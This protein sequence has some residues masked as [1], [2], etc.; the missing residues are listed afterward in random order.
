MKIVIFGCD[1]HAYLLPKVEHFIQKFWPTCPYDIVACIP[2]LGA[3]VGFEIVNLGKDHEFAT[4]ARIFLT[5]HYDENEFLLWLDDYLIRGPVNTA[6]VQAADSLIRREDIDAVRLSYRFTPKYLEPFPEDARFRVIPP[7]IRYSFSQQITMWNT[8]T[9]L[10]NLRDGETAWRLETAGSRRFKKASPKTLLG[11]T[12]PTI[13]KL[14][15]VNKGKISQK[16]SEWV[17]Q[18]W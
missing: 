10:A 11:V 8:D 1:Q 14:N 4:N 15:Y 12:Y 13:S 6:V 3:D 17:R 5:E 2:T 18:N 16:A 7:G 9:Y